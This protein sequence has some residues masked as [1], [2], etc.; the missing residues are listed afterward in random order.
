MGTFIDLTGQTFGRLTV[1]RITTR[2]KQN[3]WLCKCDCGSTVEVFGFNL[4]K[5]VT[6]S[7]GNHRVTHGESD[8]ILYKRYQNK[9]C[10]GV[11]E[12]WD[13]YEKFKEW[14]EAN[15]YNPEEMELRR[16]DATQPFSPD[17]SI[18]AYKS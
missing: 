6:T 17:N 2:G 15:D 13:T 9:K 3:K 10:I 8:S 11:S 1:I 12:E 7:C 18:V 14:A 5:G 16:K 4:R